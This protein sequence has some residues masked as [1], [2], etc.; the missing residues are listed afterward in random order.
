[1]HIRLWMF[2]CEV[3][4]FTNQIVAERSLFDPD[5][6]CPIFGGFGG[7]FGKKKDPDIECQGQCV[8]LLLLCSNYNRDV[9]LGLLNPMPSKFIGLCTFELLIIIIFSSQLPV[10]TIL[11]QENRITCP[12]SA[13]RYS[14]SRF[15]VVVRWVIWPAIYRHLLR[16]S[17][18]ILDTQPINSPY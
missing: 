7:V 14:N 8:F 15:P 1:M 17:G 6:E 12:P 16:T 10:L 5:I 13:C 4:Y 11:P 3:S 9:Q 2:F 18:R